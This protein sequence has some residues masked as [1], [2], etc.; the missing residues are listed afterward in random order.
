MEKPQRAM[1]A[2]Q[3][4][5]FLGNRQRLIVE[6][7]G[8]D[9]AV[10]NLLTPFNHAAAIA[11]NINPRDGDEIVLK[12]ELEGLADALEAFLRPTKV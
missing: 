11:M 1:T 9:G 12:H 10:L 3:W 4:E 2:E 7:F 8:G 5:R 6:G